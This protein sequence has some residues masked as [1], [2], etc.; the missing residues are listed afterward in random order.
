MSIH[1]FKNPIKSQAVFKKKKSTSSHVRVKLPLNKQDR[2]IS[3]AARERRHIAS[4]QTSQHHGVILSHVLKEITANLLYF[5]KSLVENKNSLRIRLHRK[6]LMM[7]S[8]QK[9]NF[10]DKKSKMQERQT[11][12]GNVTTILQVW[13]VSLT[14]HTRGILL[15]KP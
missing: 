8:K 4:Q 3:K 10:R 12:K 6:F 13:T 1:R 9:E 5:P 14:G 7:Y 15:P 11:C 2:E